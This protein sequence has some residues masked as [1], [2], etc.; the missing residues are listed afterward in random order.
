MSLGYSVFSIN[1]KFNPLSANPTKWSNTLN[2]FVGKYQR[3]VLVRLTVR[4]KNPPLHVR[5]FSFTTYPH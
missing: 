4:I 2:Q 1:I 3:I 5:N